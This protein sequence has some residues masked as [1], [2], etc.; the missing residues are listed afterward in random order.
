M[1]D[2]IELLGKIYN[3]ARQLKLDDTRKFELI[4]SGFIENVNIRVKYQIEDVKNKIQEINSFGNFIALAA[5]VV[6]FFA[7]ITSSVV[8]KGGSFKL[9]LDNNNAL[10]VVILIFIAI[11]GVLGLMLYYIIKRRFLYKKLNNLININLYI[12]L[13][14][15]KMNRY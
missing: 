14:L 3:L 5:L 1:E 6:S 13:Y 12:E 2:I 9:D 7:F 10:L 11:S 4:R 8:Y 15:K